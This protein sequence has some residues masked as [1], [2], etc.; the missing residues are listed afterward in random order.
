MNNHVFAIHLHLRKSL[1]TSA[2]L[3][4]VYCSMFTKEQNL[5]RVIAVHRSPGGVRRCSLCVSPR[6][7]FRFRASCCLTDQPFERVR[8]YSELFAKLSTLPLVVLQEL[9]IVRSHTHTVAQTNG[10]SLFDQLTNT[11]YSTPA[12]AIISEFANKRLILL[13][14][15]AA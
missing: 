13:Y 11:T 9:V 12:K 4:H 7:S 10:Q 14:P 5:L 8:R 1:S 2:R 3:L 15:I 6:K